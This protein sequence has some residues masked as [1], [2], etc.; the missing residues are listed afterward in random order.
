MLGLRLVAGG[1]ICAVQ[2]RA[3][4]HLGPAAEHQKSNAFAEAFCSCTWASRVL[5]LARPLMT[6]TLARTWRGQAVL[7]LGTPGG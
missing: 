6:R 3:A 5:A 4:R 2:A 1:Y 7:A